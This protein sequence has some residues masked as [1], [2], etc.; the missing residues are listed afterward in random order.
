MVLAES[1]YADLRKTGVQ[2]QL[3]NPGFIRTRLTEKNDFHMPFLM[4]P[5]H[6]ARVMFEHMNTDRFKTSF[7]M[8]FSWLFRVSQFLPD[9]AYYRLFA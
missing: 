7:P 9:W 8:L 2:V 6:A 3:A 4:E 1:I 5:D